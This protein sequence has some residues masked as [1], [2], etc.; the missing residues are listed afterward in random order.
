MYVWFSGSWM[1]SD[2]LIGQVLTVG[3]CSFKA[4]FLKSRL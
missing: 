3:R 4:N 1:N 2:T